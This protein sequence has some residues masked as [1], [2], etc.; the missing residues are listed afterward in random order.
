MS[1][2]DMSF[3]AL[4]RK[5]AGMGYGW[6]GTEFA[7]AGLKLRVTPVHKSLFGGPSGP[8]CR[9]TFQKLVDRYNDARNAQGAAA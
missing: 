5:A 2:R 7:H 4:Q 3:A 6:N 8:D 9:S 1:S